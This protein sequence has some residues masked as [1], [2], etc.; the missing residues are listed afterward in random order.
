M[1]KKVLQSKVPMGNWEQREQNRIEVGFYTSDDVD[2]RQAIERAHQLSVSFFTLHSTFLLQGLQELLHRHGAEE[3]RKSHL[4]NPP[5]QMTQNGS[6][7]N[8]HNWKL[9]NRQKSIAGVHYCP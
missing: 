2:S 3:T 4:A 9:Y 7:L 1:L 6:A 8:K 5:T